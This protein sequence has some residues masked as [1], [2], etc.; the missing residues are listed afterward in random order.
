MSELTG[1][2]GAMT[3]QMKTLLEVAS[4]RGPSLIY[5]RDASVAT[6]PNLE[7]ASLRSF[8]Q[9]KVITLRG[10]K[11]KDEGYAN[12]VID[13]AGVVIKRFPNGSGSSNAWIREGAD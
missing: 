4:T 7:Q 6:A 1:P 13:E 3:E 12:L 8:Q 5:I 10:P 2:D 9:T 11:T